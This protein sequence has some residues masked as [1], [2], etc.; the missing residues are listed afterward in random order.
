[1]C[2]DNERVS[3]ERGARDAATHAGGGPARAVDATPGSDALFD[4]F[5]EGSSDHVY[6]KHLEGRFIRVND[7]LA[8]WLGL[9]DPAEASEGRIS[10]SSTPSTRGSGSRTSLRS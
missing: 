1:M 4:A 9:A 6:F 2:S 10:T 7:V 8:R 3:G 5:M